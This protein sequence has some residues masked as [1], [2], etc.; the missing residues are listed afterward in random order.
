MLQLLEIS[1]FLLCLAEFVCFAV[2]YAGY[3][4]FRVDRLSAKFTLLLLFLV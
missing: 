3:S 2:C 1:F 4:L